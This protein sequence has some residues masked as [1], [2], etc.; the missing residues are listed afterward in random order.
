MQVCQD[1]KDVVNSNVFSTVNNVHVTV[2][3]QDCMERMHQLLLH[4]IRC[5]TLIPELLYQLA[6]IEKLKLRRN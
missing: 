1:H 4:Y 3:A 6:D 5:I 2:N